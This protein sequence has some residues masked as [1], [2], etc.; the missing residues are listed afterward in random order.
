[1]KIGMRNKL[2]CGLL[3]TAALSIGFVLIQYTFFELHLM[4]QWPLVLFLLGIVVIG[5]SAIFG[6]WKVMVGT[7]VGYIIGFILGMVLFA[8]VGNYDPN[9]GTYRYYGWWIWLLSFLAFIVTS[10]VWV[11]LSR[12]RPK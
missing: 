6:A 2:I 8:D 12:N 3:S 10:I 11:F 9:R 4:V 5:I 1:M 7:V